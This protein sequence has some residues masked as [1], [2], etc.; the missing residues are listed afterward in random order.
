MY[1]DLKNRGLAY[2]PAFQ[3]TNQL[4]ILEDEILLYIETIVEDGNEHASHLLYPPLA[5]TALQ[6]TLSI[7]PGN[8][9]YV[10]VAID[11]VLFYQSP[12]NACWCH[13]KITKRN[14]DSFIATYYF[15]D[16]DGKLLA[17]LRDSS[18]QEMPSASKQED[19]FLQN[20]LY[21]PKWITYE[22]NFEE[23]VR[24][25]KDCLVFAHESQVLSDI[26]DM[27]E[28]QG[29]SYTNIFNGSEFQKLKAEHFIIDGNSKFDI[30]RVL[31]SLRDKEI[32]HIFYLWPLSQDL[33][34]DLDKMVSTCAQL[35][36]LIQAIITLWECNIKFVIITQNSQ[37][38]TENDSEL[39]L[40]LSPYWDLANLYEMN[41]RIFIVGWLILES[42][43][44]SRHSK[45]GFIT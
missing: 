3:C 4:W 24:E 11:K 23:S 14:S 25:I 36:Y 21:E 40:N 29:I 6:S 42:R 12:Q 7:V 39:N 33:S 30:E 10:P 44:L 17:E 28:Q 20:S 31:N 22:A 5:D 1:A 43:H 15:Y 13:G 35:T 16:H 26:R 32:S 18:S 19:D 34:P 27:L 41:I 45:I 37:L 9:P 8:A 2:G 38:V